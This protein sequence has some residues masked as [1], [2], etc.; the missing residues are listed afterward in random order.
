[1]IAAACLG[2]CPAIALSQVSGDLT[3]WHTV[4]VDFAGPSVGETGVGPNP[5]LDYRLQVTFTGPG[6]QSYNV[7]GFFDGDGIGG[8]TGNV[9]RTRFSPDQA[10]QWTYSASFR[11]GANVA[12]DLNPIAGTATSF[13]GAS[14]FFNVAP[15]NPSA[16]GFLS[17]GRLEYVGGHYLKYRDGGYWIKGGADSP[18]N[19]LGYN[20]FDNTPT[21]KLDFSQHP[22]DWQAG[23]PDWDGLAAGTTNGR[24]IIGAINYLSS[25]RVNSIY[26]LPMNI[27][28][29][30]QDSSPYVTVGNWAGSAANDNVHFD[31]SKL[32]QWETFFSHAQAK[33]VNLHVVLGEAEAANKNE[34][35]GATLGTERKLFYREMVARFGHYN[36]LVWNISEEY[37]F[38]LVLG[39]DK[40]RS[41]ADYIGAI[42]P[43]GHPTTVHNQDVALS[44]N[45]Y[46]L[47]G[48]SRWDLTSIQRGDMVDGL[49]A[50]VEDLRTRSANAGRPLAIMIDEPGSI[51][52]DAGG[53]DG[54]RKRM[55]WDIYLSGGGVEWFAETQDQ[56]LDNFRLHEQIYRETWHARKFLEQNTRFWLMSPNDALVRGEDIDFG[57]AEVFAILGEEYA[58]YFPDGSNDDNAGGAPELNL[59]GYDGMLFQ[60]RWYNPR[61]GE[62]AGSP[63]ILAG[64]DWVSVGF[65]PDGFQNINDWAALVTVVPEP[66]TLAPLAIGALALLRRRAC[67]RDNR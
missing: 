19:W 29:D 46:K 28:G 48:E 52:Q 16:P 59:T 15:L 66:T 32:R 55:M 18:E 44:N 14:G 20:G 35:D 34:L 4:N 11:E 60:L 13:N 41:F 40:I 31:I 62:F 6:G 24:A 36:S 42:D 1:M 9:W 26:F 5:F 17:Q 64:G 8:A 61:T 22:T 50:V 65:T 12:I 10:G 57:G 23:N 30:G 7:P 47:L 27:G 45:W 25:Q 38:Q 2:A 43:Y 39:E 3:K 51:D 67:R 53:P 33:G 63:V 21:A 37:D 58:I 49:G 56:S 54:V